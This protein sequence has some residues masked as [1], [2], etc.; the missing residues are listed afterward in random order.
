MSKRSKIALGTVQFGL[1]YGISNKEGKPNQK[2]VQEIITF[3]KNTGIELIDTASAYGNAEAVLGNEDL[4]SFK[5]VSKFLP[6]NGMNNIPDSLRKSLSQLKVNRLYGYLAH[7]ANSVSLNDWEI[8]KAYKNDGKIEK[9]GFSYQS[10]DEVE[11]TLKSGFIP[12]LVQIP[13]NYF[14]NRFEA[15]CLKLKEYNVEIH[16]RSTFLQGLFFMSITELTNSFQEVQ[17]LILELQKRFRD[18]LAGQLLNYV[19][20]QEFIDYVVIGVQNKSQLETNLQSL[21]QALKLS[22]LDRNISGN[23]L[24]PALWN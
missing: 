11:R 7:R 2:S 13:F 17:D 23:V 20:N 15:I 8:L 12:D 10:V 3:A 22:K 1:D 19:V 5:I 24:N 6:E 18:Q 14:D 4:S 21:N 9:I 16:S